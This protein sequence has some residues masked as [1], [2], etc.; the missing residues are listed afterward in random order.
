ME[1][2][3][4]GIR[5]NKAKKGAKRQKPVDTS[6]NHP[7]SDKEDGYD[8]A[9]KVPRSVLAGCEKSFTATNETCE[10]TSTQFFAVTA[11]MALLCRH[12]CVIW[13]V[14]MRSASEK[15]HYALAL[16]E[17]LFQHLPLHY[18]VGLL[19]DVGL[20]HVFGHQWP[21][22]IIYHPRKCNR[23]G[24]SDGEGCKRFWNSIK[25][26]IAYLRVC[27]VQ[28]QT[29]PLPRQTRNQG[30]DAV[31]EAIR[32][33]KARDIL[34]KHVQDQENI[35]LD[36][37]ASDHHLC[38][39]E[40]CLAEAKKA[41]S[42][43]ESWVHASES[44]LGV[45]ER[46][47]LGKLLGS[48]FI[49]ARMNTRALKLCLCERLCSWKFELDR[50][51]QSYRN[52]VNECK[53][54]HHLEDSVKRRDPSIQKL[55]CD[56]NNLCDCKAPPGSVCPSKIVMKGLF[57]LDVND[58]IWQDAGLE[59]SL[60][61]A[62]TDPPLW[63]CDDLVRSGIQ[64]WNV[65]CSA[66]DNTASHHVLDSL[67]LRYQLQ[68][69]KDELLHVLS[70]WKKSL[71]SLPADTVIPAWGP[72]D[73]E[74]TAARIAQV[75]SRLYDDY[76]DM[77]EFRPSIGVDELNLSDVESL[78]EDLIDTL[79]AIDLADAF[80]GEDFDKLPVSICGSPPSVLF[81]PWMSEQMLWDSH[82]RS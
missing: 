47:K 43:A 6:R 79:E 41:L 34:R 40:L 16:V 33:R 20:F 50:I 9:L 27:E 71:Q 77:E 18:T 1:G 82:V 60:D 62:T 24:L 17:T 26:L 44:A 72:T 15:Q 4:E 70:I 52:H 69:R 8:G 25:K 56:Y 54:H 30:K 75:T 76:D 55:T 19:Y 61:G 7:D 2:Y 12:D 3:V 64:E 32:L 48:P 66:Y 80:R 57:A 74:I 81:F 45:H 49:A 63:L 22:Q 73:D 31:S 29:K 59:D 68:L 10:K 11:L 21:C 35:I 51:E 14:N 42:S 37:L 67:E 23:F 5:P 46:T 28:A 13:V 38:D 65:T 39:A 58:E 78:D 53:V 36:P